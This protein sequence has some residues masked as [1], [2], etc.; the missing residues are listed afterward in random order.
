MLIV[1]NLP[2][3]LCMKDE[4]TFLSMLIPGPKQPGNDIDIYL[5]PLINEL[6]ELWNGVYTYDASQKKFFNLK[7]MLLWTINDFPAYGN[8]AGC[9]TKGKYGCP[10]CGENTNAEWLPHSKKMA[11]CNHIRFLPKNHPYRR[12]KY[13]PTKL[14]E[15][16]PQCPAIAIGV[17]VAK[18]LRNVVN[19]FGKGLKRSRDEE[20]DTMW[21]KKSIFFGLP[22]WEVLVVRHNLDVMHVEKNV[23][24]S[25]INTLLDCKGK[26]KD[27]YNSRL[28]LEEKNIMPHLHSYEVD[29]IPHLPAATYTLSKS[30]KKLFC[31]RL[32]D[33]KLPSGYSSNISNCVDVEKH[34]LIGL[35]SHDF[36]VLMQQLL[37]VAIR[38]IM[39]E[40]PR[41]A[42]LRLSKFFHGLCQRVVDKEEIIKLELEAAEILCKLEDYFPPSFFDPMIHLVVH[43]PREVRLCGP[44]QFRWMYHFERYM[45]VLKGFVSNY[46]RPEGS[47]ANRYLS[48]ECVRF[49]ETFL[50]QSDKPIGCAD[51]RDDTLLEDRPLSAGKCI[52]LDRSDVAIAHR[53][54]LF[55]SEIAAPYLK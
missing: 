16:A 4:F 41:E 44:V 5:E 48:L 34:K 39:E 40:G 23:C 12:K 35:K 51:V 38:G 24:E 8:L 18:Q 36:H 17:E 1:Y 33:L 7:A 31:K 10:I 20:N 54:V 55:N 49:C 52:K 27:H 50:K 37:A 53:Y 43:L 32:F 46:A 11:Y 21:K 14:R 30:D 13:P 2:P 15:V 42:I 28:D 22:Y 19:D 9:A 45:K 25:I 26:S 6:Q 3:S 29:G 47:I